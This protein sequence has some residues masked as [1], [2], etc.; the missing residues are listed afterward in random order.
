MM[1]LIEQFEKALGIQGWDAADHF[2]GDR[3]RT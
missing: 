1:L 3:G 2:N